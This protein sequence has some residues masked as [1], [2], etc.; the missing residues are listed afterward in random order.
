MINVIIVEDQAVVR[1]SLKMLINSQGIGNVVAEFANGE[2]FMAILPDY[3]PDVV[4]I[5]INM[6]VM[7]GLETTKRA[8]RERPDLNILAL[9]SHG[10]EASYFKMV[11]AGVKG[12][13]LKGS[14]MDDLSQAIKTVAK[15]ES[16]FS[17][18]LLKAVATYITKG[19]NDKSPLTK[20]EVKLLLLMIEGLTDQEI[21]TH[22][23]SSRESIVK[24]RSKILSKTNCCNTVSL[25]M[26]AIKNKIIE[27]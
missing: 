25:T 14:Q 13:I 8:M 23:K 26:Y 21:A 27:I 22:I 1:Q 19:E 18:E 7:D 4:L 11:D 3:N 15:G 6:P 5:D 20:D 2:E 12:F 16:W 10:D 17:P 24:K 9:S